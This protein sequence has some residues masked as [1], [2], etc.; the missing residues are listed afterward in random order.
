[1]TFLLTG[2]VEGAAADPD[3]LKRL[4]PENDPTGDTDKRVKERCYLLANGMCGTGT[5]AA[6]LNQGNPTV[7]LDE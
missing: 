7:H 5:G 2:F 3:D 1:M 6:V 4:L